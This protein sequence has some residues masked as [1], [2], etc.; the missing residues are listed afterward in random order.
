MTGC[1][2]LQNYRSSKAGRHWTFKILFCRQR[3]VRVVISTKP[4]GRS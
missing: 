4:P 1:S 2:D 3:L